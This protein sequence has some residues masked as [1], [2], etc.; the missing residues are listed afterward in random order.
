MVVNRKISKK[1]EKKKKKRNIVSIPT[2]K[3][4]CCCWDRLSQKKSKAHQS[5][6]KPFV[7]IEKKK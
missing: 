3:T 4:C 6:L 1:K 7:L 2:L 5:T